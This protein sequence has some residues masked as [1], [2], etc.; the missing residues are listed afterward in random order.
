MSVSVIDPGEGSGCVSGVYC[1][2]KRVLHYNAYM[3][4]TP[5]EC[6]FLTMDTETLHTCRNRLRLR[7]ASLSSHKHSFLDKAIKMLLGMRNQ[8]DEKPTFPGSRGHNYW[9]RVGEEV[10]YLCGPSYSKIPYKFVRGSI[11]AIGKRDSNWSLSITIDGVVAGET[12]D[13]IRCDYF[14]P[15]VLRI[16][17]LVYLKENPDFT[18]IWLKLVFTY[19]KE[20]GYKDY[21]QEGFRK[22]LAEF[23]A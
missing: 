10:Y 17:D 12:S 20:E 23:V 14:S 21:S 22:A 2:I 9:G 1:E 16:D 13:P 5:D 18:D 11:S 3:L 19:Y 7:I 6:C 4:S 15:Q 8:A